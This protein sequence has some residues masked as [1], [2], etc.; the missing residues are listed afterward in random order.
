MKININGIDF[1]PIVCANFD[2]DFLEEWTK[3]PSTSI[4]NLHS[5]AF[6]MSKKLIE[7]NPIKSNN[8]LTLDISD[9]NDVNDKIQFLLQNNFIFNMCSFVPVETR[10]ISYLIMI[11]SNKEKSFT[12][13]LSCSSRAYVIKLH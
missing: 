3:Y 8:I 7:D 5:N 4:F 1:E 9:E 12:Y 6:F 11:L 13:K 2:K 10:N